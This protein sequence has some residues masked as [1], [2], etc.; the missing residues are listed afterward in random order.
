MLIQGRWSVNDG[1][2]LANCSFSFTNP[3]LFGINGKLLSRKIV[4]FEA[5]Y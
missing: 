5:P 2:S 3:L 1:F 4:Y